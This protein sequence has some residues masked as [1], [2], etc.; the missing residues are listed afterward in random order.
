[1]RRMLVIVP[2][3]DAEHGMNPTRRRDSERASFRT[4]VFWIAAGLIRLDVSTK[5][6]GVTYSIGSRSDPTG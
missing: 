5:T 3:T 1:M 6:L 2:L 4:R